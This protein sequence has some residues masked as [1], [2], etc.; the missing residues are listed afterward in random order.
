[1]FVFVAG[2]WWKGSARRRR[3]HPGGWLVCVP[4]TGRDVANVYAVIDVETTGLRPSWHDRIAEIA[5]VQVDPTGRVEGSWATLVNPKRDLGPQHI[6]GITAAEARRAP[7]FDQ[8]AG[9]LTRLLCGRTLVAHNL[10]F[11]AMFLTAEYRRLGSEIPVHHDAGLCT[12]GLAAHYLPSG[13]SLADCCLIAG[14]T[15]TN[16]HSAVG[17]AQAAASLLACYLNRVGQPPPWART[18]SAARTAAWP[19]LP[20]LPV[21]CVTREHPGQ[22]PVHFLSRLVARLPRVDHPRADA[23]LDLLDRV[24]IDRVISTT[25]ADALL[26]FASRLGLG[27]LEVSDLHQRYLEDLAVATLE[28]GKVT[29]DEHQDLVQVAALLGLGTC[30]LD[31]ALN[32]ARTAGR[33]ARP[34][35][36]QFALAPG[37]VIVLTGTFSQPKEVI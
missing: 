29:D 13:R 12:M 17:D 18:L 21:N 35:Y 32:A 36:G 37:D 33:S 14:I 9:H 1:M 25:E 28:D 23:Y 26:A 19:D 4:H 30:E 27:R 7:T 3:C 31:L 20:V 16:A 22:T 6:H 34:R 5:V 11:D 10:A 2:T 24:L 15:P 8:I